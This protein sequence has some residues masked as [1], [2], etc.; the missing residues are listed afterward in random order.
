MANAHSSKIRDGALLFRAATAEEAPA[1]SSLSIFDL[2]SSHHPPD[3]AFCLILRGGTSRELGRGR[4]RSLKE[5]SPPEARRDRRGPGDGG[6]QQDTAIGVSDR[7]GGCCGR[8]AWS[9]RC[10]AQQQRQC[11]PFLA[12]QKW[13]ISIIT[14]HMKSVGWRVP[15][16]LTQEAALLLPSTF[17]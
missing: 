5:E 2:A 7:R 8:R 14:D 1:F 12:R 3:A 6:N 9:N 10:C 13:E 11:Q 17:L 16:R 4:K 15:D